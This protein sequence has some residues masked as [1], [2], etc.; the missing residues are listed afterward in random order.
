MLTAECNLED[1]ELVS[2][3][4]D[5]SSQSH[6]NLYLSAVFISVLQQYDE[7]GGTV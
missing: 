5:N 3:E 2:A 6:Q 1:T 7:G 4:T